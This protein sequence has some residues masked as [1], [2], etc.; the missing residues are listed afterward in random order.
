M[1]LDLFTIIAIEEGLKKAE[2]ILFNAL[3]SYFYRMPWIN[4]YNWIVIGLTKD[5]GS[6]NCL[7][8]TLRQCPI[9][10]LNL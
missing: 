9:H 6:K 8:S 3:S 5:C 7:E 2:Q 1:F 4:K 10:Q